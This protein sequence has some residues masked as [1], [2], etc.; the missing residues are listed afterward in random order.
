MLNIF[1]DD[2]FSLQRLTAAFNDIPEVPTLIG[3]L[4][5]FE[6]QGVDTTVVSIE[7]Q[8]DGLTLVAERPYG[9]T[10]EVV[11]GETR[12]LVD[13][14][15][16]HFQRDDSVIAAEVQGKRA[17]GTENELETV[18]ERVNMKM[19][20]HAR[21]FD[22]TMEHLR[23]GA[24]KGLVLNKAGGTIL[25]TFDKFDVDQPAE[26]AF[27][28]SNASSDVLGKC[29]QVL[30]Q[31][32]DALEGRGTPSRVWGIAGDTFLLQ[33]WE[34]AAVRDTYK[35]WLAAVAL[36][37]DPRLP[38]EFGGIS[39]VRYH[40]KPKAKKGNNNAPLVSLTEAKFVAAG[41]PELFIT[42]YAPADY[43]ET[44]NT[45]GLPRYAKQFPTANGKARQ[46][47]MQ[48]NAICL[49]TKPDSLQRAKAGA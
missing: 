5:I 19:A 47:E 4:G 7:K 34:H 27:D 22:F 36:R 44:V 31:T 42:R 13:I 8:D 10:G 9:G 17:F 21:S 24:I 3:G 41:V 28:L 48:M 38:F 2:A 45:I 14:R 25:D 1:D 49:C 32:E 26:I 29:Q 46:L 12:N 18:Q 37:N 43:E 15:I 11:G 33:L 35:N 40:T 20:R 23:V 16:P 39:W 6:E 30:D